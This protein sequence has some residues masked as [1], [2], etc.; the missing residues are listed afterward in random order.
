MWFV[1]LLRIGLCRDAGEGLPLPV[2]QTVRWVRIAIGSFTI[3]SV[4]CDLSRTLPRDRMRAWRKT[5][6]PFRG[7]VSEMGR[8]NVQRKL[9]SRTAPRESCYEGSCVQCVS[10][11]NSK[12]L[13]CNH[14]GGFCES[15]NICRRDEDRDDSEN[16]YCDLITR[17]CLP[18]PDPCT[19][20][21]L[22]FLRAMRRDYGPLRASRGPC[23]DDIRRKHSFA[24]A[25]PLVFETDQ[26]RMDHLALCPDDDDFFAVFL[27][28]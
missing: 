25:T 2:V 3:P 12:G 8:R 4:G 5:A 1:S 7:D 11:E 20:D 21:L 17:M 24:S 27:N 22:F 14:R 16:Q 28:R 26:L 6:I 23:R 9:R 18:R 15:E 19:S 13:R 10:D